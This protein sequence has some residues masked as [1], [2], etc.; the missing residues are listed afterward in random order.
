MEEDPTPAIQLNLT[1]VFD[2]DFAEA[3]KRFG[4]S[5]CPR[6]LKIGFPLPPLPMPLEIPAARESDVTRST[7][8]I[9]VSDTT[10]V[11]TASSI[12]NLAGVST[13]LVPAIK[14]PSMSSSEN[15]VHLTA[16]AA[17]ATALKSGSESKVNL[18]PLGST[19]STTALGGGGR[20]NQQSAMEIATTSTA[21]T[22]G[23]GGAATA[24]NAEEEEEI[25]KVQV[26]GW[27]ISTKLVEI[28]SNVLTGCTSISQ[29]VLWNC[30][31]N[32]SHFTYI[33]GS[34]LTSNIR[35]LSL[36]QNP[37]IPEQLYTHLL[38][39]DSLLKHLSL[40]M[41]KITCFNQS[42]TSMGLGRNS[43]GDD[44]VAAV[45]KALS[46][47][48]L[49]HDELTTRK[50]ALSDLERIRREQEDDP[51]IKKAKSK[52]GNGLGRLQNG[53]KSEE[54]LSKKEVVVDPKNAKKG[55]PGGGAAAAVPAK[56]AAGGGKPG[57]PAA[58]GNKDKKTPDAPPAAAGAAG[59]KGGAP[60]AP[61]AAADKGGKDKKGGGAAATPAAANAKGKKG[62][63]EEVK[64]EVDD[65]NDANSTNEP[66]F[67]YNG[68]TYLIGNRTLN[69][70]NV[71]QNGIT[72]VGL[73]YLLDAVNEQELSAESAPEG[74]LGLFRVSMMDN[75][76]EKDNAMHAQLQTQAAADKEKE[77]EE[78][79]RQGIEIE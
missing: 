65:S 51:W 28:L 77:G 25:A 69:N 9:N 74:L 27:R 63:A 1:G 57:A 22:L 42:L 6:L 59:K 35:H 19:A 26:R 10:A 40:R 38:V 21:I 47:Y 60:A 46:N 66:T 24:N 75:A 71:R 68:Q 62:K 52:V 15:I 7:S 54:N 14:G 58:G 2:Q 20:S 55:A 64:E 32:E 73:K 41:N 72:E 61:P 11:V 56:A 31:L 34:I 76:F 39:D 78:G 3:C 79:D 12:E 5:E 16:T 48:S 23:E 44:G 50:K 30:G 49:Q 67:E 18:G 8:E 53:K 37:D 45:A 70:L 36:D 13:S 33:L 29:L 4:V 17:T 43:I